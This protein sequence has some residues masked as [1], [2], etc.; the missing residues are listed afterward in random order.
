MKTFRLITLPA[1][2]I[3]CALFSTGCASTQPTVNTWRNPAFSPTPASTIALKL[4]EGATPK[5][6]ETGQLLQAELQSEGFKLVS[7]EKADYLLSYMVTDNQ[8]EKSWM[9]NNSAPA[10]QQ[11]AYVQGQIGMTPSETY[12]NSQVE[13]TAVVRT[14][15]I[16]LFLYTN[17]KTNP[18]GL[19]M[20]WQGTLT[21]GKDPAP[22]DEQVLFKTLLHY[23]GGDE[24]GA[25]KLTP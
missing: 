11:P 13:R 7:E 16:R 19:Q 18:A 1:L 20:V 22:G 4:H 6:A 10:M 2:S 23:F 8:V 12:G 17:P 3:V 9:E 14:C 5:D 15:D 24:N 25:V 21:L